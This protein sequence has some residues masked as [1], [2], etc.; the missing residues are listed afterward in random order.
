MG[1]DL[2][3]KEHRSWNMSRIRSKD[4]APELIVRQALHSMGYR[5]RLHNKNL[6]GCPDITMSRLKALV[7]VHGCF[8]HRH[9]NCS[10]CTIPTANQEFWLEKFQRTIKRD[11]KNLYSLRKLGWKVLVV[12]EC[13]TKDKKKLENKLHKFMSS[14][15]QQA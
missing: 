10:R 6:P 7:L 5:F 14:I 11:K 4:T 1:P 9:K 3:S 2:S 13:Q 12:W 15:V 8:W